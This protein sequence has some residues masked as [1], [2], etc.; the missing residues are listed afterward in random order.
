MTK[1]ASKVHRKTTETDVQV[2]LQ[3]D[4]TG[5]SAVKTGIPFMDHMLS[6]F[7]KHGLFDL[8]I[9]AAGDLEVDDHHLVEDLGI[10][11]GQAVKESVGVKEGISRYGHALV[12][13]DEALAEALVDLSG[14]PFF[15]YDVRCKAKKIKRFE[16]ALVPEFLRAFAFSACMNLHVGLRYGSNSHHILEAV[17]KAVSRAVRAAVRIDSRIKG[18][19]STKGRL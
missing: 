15:V 3:L 12:P 14:R 17:F 10:C 2:S 13:M 1:R 7:A 18:V 4:G 19:L 8:E 6:L 9:E 5:E 16:I 11:L